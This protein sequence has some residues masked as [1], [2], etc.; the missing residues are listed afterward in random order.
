MCRLRA[1]GECVERLRVV[2]NRVDCI[3]Q[4]FQHGGAVRLLEPLTGHEVAQQVARVSILPFCSVA[5]A[6]PCGP[7]LNKSFGNP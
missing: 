1:E 2:E 4:P 5:F 6:E 7:V 3:G